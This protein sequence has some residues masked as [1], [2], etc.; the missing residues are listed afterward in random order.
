ME[1]IIICPECQGT[2]RLKTRKRK[3]NLS[4][5]GRFVRSSAIPTKEV[6][7]LDPLKQLKEDKKICF[8]CGG[9]GTISI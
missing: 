8:R 1:N 2:G 7:T 3:M 5:L 6:S 9:L 4:D